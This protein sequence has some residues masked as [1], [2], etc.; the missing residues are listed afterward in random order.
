M[1]QKLATFIAIS[2]LFTSVCINAKNDRGQWEEAYENALKGNEQRAL[3]LLQ[4]RYNA[5]PPGI[6]KLYVTSKLHGFM[7]LHG[8]PY[9]GNRNSFNLEFTHQEERFVD[10][11]NSEEQLDFIA[12]RKGFLSLLRYADEIDSL[13]GKILLE[14]HLCRVLNRQA[15]FYQADAYCSSL[16]THIQDIKNPILPKYKALRVIANNQ[17]FVGNYQAALDT[18]QELIK[19]MPSYVD[20]SGVY[21]DA[22][23]LLANLG[24]FEQAKKYINIALTMRSSEMT[25]LKL[26]QTHHS[27]GKVMLKQKKYEFAT[28]HF[29]QSKLISQQSNYLYGITFAQLGLGQAY[30]G[31][32]K[33]EQGNSYL[34]DALDNATKQ[35]NSQIRGEIY[36]TLA[37]THK[38]QSK[39]IAGLEFAQ[40]AFN[41]STSI[42]SERLTSQS[43]RMLAEIS[44]LQGNYDKA[45]TYYRNYA[46][47]E[48]DKRDKENKNAFIALDSARRNYSDQIQTENLTNENQELRSQKRSLEQKNNLYGVALLILLAVIFT[49]FSYQRRKTARLELDA[50]SG[51]LNRAACI[52]KI[53]K[54]LATSNPDNRNVLL[55]IDLDDFKAINDSYGHPTGDR[56]LKHVI[57]IIKNQMNKHDLSG[58]LGGEEFI[59]LF[60]D[61][62]ELDVRERVMRLHKAIA[63]TLFSSSCR[64]SIRLT[65]SISYLA[66][67]KALD[68]FDEL[69]SILD[70]ALYQAKRNGKNC[71]VDAYNDP[72]YLTPS[73]CVPEQSSPTLDH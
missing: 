59:V 14:Y 21:N 32:D 7:L 9:H 58:R 48:L 5:L 60:K 51:A 17:E 35:D 71:V 42:G 53:K 38:D 57:E 50:L 20:S 25:P 3:S 61:V 10:A 70:Q 34:L 19:V 67:T 63:H 27:M 22:G 36:L 8:Q 23:L 39:Y 15:L 52:R 18:Y 49:Q 1:K 29:M 62:D 54:Q 66:T 64:Q 33:Y 2:S 43:L 6:E 72:I 4:D 56:A 37:T 55:M 30:I 65:A 68:D 46:K 13:D 41:L 69:Y 28:T 44:E 40:Q 45:L 24:H 47:S 11:L 12:A 73:A 26:A 16:N 31:L